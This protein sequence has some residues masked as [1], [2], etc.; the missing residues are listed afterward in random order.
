[1]DTARRASACAVNS[2]MTATYWETGRRIVESEQRGK[3][4]PIMARI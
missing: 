2:M 3:S 1:L 4:A